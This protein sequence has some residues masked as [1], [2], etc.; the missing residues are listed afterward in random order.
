MLFLTPDQQCQSTEGTVPLR[1]SEYSQVPRRLFRLAI[2]LVLDALFG[3]AE[4]RLDNSRL[5]LRM[6]RTVF[7]HVRLYQQHTHTHTPV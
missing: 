7:L 6:F 2:N 1:V 3:L 5:E 4:E